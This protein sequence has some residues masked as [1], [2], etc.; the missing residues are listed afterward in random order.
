MRLGISHQGLHLFEAPAEVLEAGSGPPSGMRSE[1]EL[2]GLGPLGELPRLLVV[3][4]R[5]LQRLVDFGKEFLATRE[6]FAGRQRHG[7]RKSPLPQRPSASDGLAREPSNGGR[8]QK[9]GQHI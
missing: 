6:R 4:E 9:K 1:L 5:R 7:P 2:D 3:L 8:T